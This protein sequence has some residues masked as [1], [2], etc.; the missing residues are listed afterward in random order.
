MNRNNFRNF[1]G[2][3]KKNW[4]EQYIK[5]INELVMMLLSP[6]D[7][8][9]PSEDMM[10]AISFL[11]VGTKE[12]EFWAL[13]FGKS[14]RCLWE[15]LL[16]TLVWE[17]M[18]EM[19]LLKTLPISTEFLNIRWTRFITYY[20]IYFFPYIFNVFQLTWWF[21]VKLSKEVF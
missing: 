13:F 4:S 12:E 18:E 11:T 19:L 20:W 15:Y 17:S 1:E 8:V 6:I 21:M 16:F 2:R 9:E 10:K 7:L 5:N 14:E 3:W